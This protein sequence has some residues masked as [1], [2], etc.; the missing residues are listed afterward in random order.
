MFWP[1][2]ARNELLRL[3]VGS[4]RDSVFVQFGK[5]RNMGGNP[6]DSMSLSLIDIGA[7]DT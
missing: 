7:S 6:I 4:E 5:A 3:S 2:P 1:W